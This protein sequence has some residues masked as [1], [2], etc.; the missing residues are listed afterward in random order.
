M[1]RKGTLAET[2]DILRVKDARKGFRR[3]YA[4][5]NTIDKIFTRYDTGAKG[6]IDAQDI[7]KQAKNIGV[8]ITLDEAQV[9]VQSAKGVDNQNE[10]NLS[11]E[12]YANFLFATSEDINVN[13]KNLTP[14]G[15][16]KIPLSKQSIRSMQP[17]EMSDFMEPPG[18]YEDD[19]TVLDQKKV[20]QN[21]I[22]NIE[23]KLIKMNRKLK[24]QFANQAAFDEE[25]KQEVPPDKNGN[26]TVD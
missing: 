11:V 7:Y 4:D 14:M 6:F 16:D 26:V 20:P 17:T 13:M 10:A 18:I 3:K 1:E 2:I 22:E 24:R 21:I 25:L 9:L 8:T 12:E 15:D 23:S 5:R 19:Y